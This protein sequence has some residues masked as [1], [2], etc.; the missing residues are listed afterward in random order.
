M[1]D[2]FELDQDIMLVEE[3]LDNDPFLNMPPRL[4]PPQAP[5]PELAKDEAVVKQEVADEFRPKRISKLKK[6]LIESQRRQ[7]MN[8]R[9]ISQVM[10]KGR[11]SK[12][13]REQ[14]N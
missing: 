5:F 11:V 6:H 1:L 3:Q 12:R 8:K 13:R 10:I 14:R 2:Y 7:K 4:E 9:Y